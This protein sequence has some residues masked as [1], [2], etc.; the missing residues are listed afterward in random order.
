MKHDA[1]FELYSFYVVRG[2]KIEELINMS[3]IEKMF[4]TEAMVKYFEIEN[5]RFGG[6]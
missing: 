5:K 1:E 4:L 6:E 3:T 2:Y